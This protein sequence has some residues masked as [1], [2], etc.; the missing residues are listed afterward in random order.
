MQNKSVQ[1]NVNVF[2]ISHIKSKFA[3]LYKIANAFYSNCAC[4]HPVSYNLK[5]RRFSDEIKVIFPASFLFSG[6]F[7]SHARPTRDYICI[8]IELHLKRTVIF[9]CTLLA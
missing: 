5:M 9:L 1:N 8:I 7:E 4:F 6:R 3:K 2:F